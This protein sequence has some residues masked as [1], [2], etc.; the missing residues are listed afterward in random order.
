MR[1]YKNIII[2]ATAGMMLLSSCKDDAFLKETLKDRLNTETAYT[3]KAQFDALSAN[4]YRSIQ[5]MYN[6]ADLT[7]EAFILG[8]GTDV[9]FEFHLLSRPCRWSD[10]MAQHEFDKRDHLWVQSVLC[11]IL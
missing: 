1:S 6:T 5:L 10:C 11:V 9:A 8:L 7:H 2:A 4:M 3:N